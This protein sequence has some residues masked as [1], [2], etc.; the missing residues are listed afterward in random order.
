MA[1]SGAVL[2]API[3]ATPFVSEEAA[4]KQSLLSC[5][6][7]NV[8]SQ[9]SN[10][11]SQ[12]S[13][14]TSRDSTMTSRYQFPVLLTDEI[15]LRIPYWTSV[16]PCGVAVCLF[17][18]AAVWTRVSEFKTPEMVDRGESSRVICYFCGFLK[19]HQTKFYTSLVVLI[20]R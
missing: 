3:V 12:L 13:N 17:V 2:L 15:D 19:N 10:M 5:N 1:Y 20:D 7:T 6:T 16:V 8:T 11:T 14:V 9:L 4:R 18:T